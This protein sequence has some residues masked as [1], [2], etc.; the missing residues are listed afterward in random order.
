MID[1]CGLNADVIPVS[2]G[3]L[4]QRL[5]ADPMTLLIFE[6]VRVFVVASLKQLS[7]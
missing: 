5:T 2:V 4:G 3:R 1:V 6:M 7:D